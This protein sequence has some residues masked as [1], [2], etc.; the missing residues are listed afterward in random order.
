MARREQQ[1]SRSALKFL[2]LA[3][4]IMTFGA[5]AA[6]AHDAASPSPL[7]ECKIDGIDEVLLCGAIEVPENRAAPDGRTIA[8]N[9]IVVPA[10]R[11]DA[12]DDPWVELVGGPGNAATDFV[13]SFSRDLRYLRADRDV[14]LIDQ[15]GTGRS[16][17]LFCAELSLHRVSSLFPRWPASGVRACRKRLSKIADLSR[18]STQD[19]AL[20]IETVRKR[21]GYGRI[22][23]FG[24]SYGTR[25]AL[26][27]MRLFPENVRSAMLW[28][29]VAPDFRRPLFYARDGQQALDRLFDDCLEDAACADAFP[30]IRQDFAAAL[31]AID[32][33]KREFAIT[34]PSDGKVHSVTLTRAGFAQGVWAALSI[35]EA[36]HRLPYVFHM[37]SQ[38]DFDAFI[39]LDVA[40]KPPRR[41]YDNAMHLSVVCP[42]ETAHATTDELTASTQGSFMPAD[43]ALEYARA[44]RIWGLA[45]NN[46][47]ALAPVRA[48]V[49]TLIVSGYMDP[50]TPPSWGEAVH[51]GLANSRHLVVRHLSHEIGGLNGAECLDNLFA[52]FLANPN[53]RDLNADCIGEISPPPF[54][55]PP[56]L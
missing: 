27:Y 29:V 54:E 39:A 34:N 46:A 40:K 48:D 41:R 19:A 17:G 49:P 28:G 9:V 11:S 45:P 7:R 14:L 50:I 23:L 15:R 1:K 38:G 10:L 5:G 33:E 3:A 6:L 12:G 21:L 56:Q 26:E 55:I 35:P 52:A 43:R 53:P 47:I 16:N 8:L 18:Y 51:Q 22:N 36:A 20:D 32:S 30:D 31:D 42:D 25:L 37:A 24:S 2:L 44:C 4:A 13:R